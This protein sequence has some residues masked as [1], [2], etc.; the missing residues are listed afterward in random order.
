MSLLTL[1]FRSRSD[2]DS[3]SCTSLSFL[4]LLLQVCGGMKERGGRSD[5]TAE[6]PITREGAKREEGASESDGEREK[7]ERRRRD[8]TKGQVK[9][10]TPSSLVSLSIGILSFSLRQALMS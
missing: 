2:T 9:I 10:A 1:G 3:F 5:K 7:R 8:P 4:F 6:L